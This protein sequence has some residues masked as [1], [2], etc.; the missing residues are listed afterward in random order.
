[1]RKLETRVEIDATRE[2]VW[3]VLTATDAYPD[4]N[5]FI[6]EVEG[7]FVAGERV[8]LTMRLPGKKPMTLR[9]RVVE[10]AP[11]ARLRWSGRLWVRGLCD[12]QH[13]FH[14]SETPRGTTEVVQVETFRGVLVP[15]LGRAIATTRLGFEAMDSALRARAEAAP[16]LA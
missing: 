10:A 13:E 14:L 1:M 2:E 16:V 8:R 7:C 6:T 15:F 3:E 4:W 9:P 12:A 11:A 5:P